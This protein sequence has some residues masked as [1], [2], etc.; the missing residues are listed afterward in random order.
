MTDKNLTIE[1]KNKL[2]QQVRVRFAPS[3]TGFLH[4]GGLR[5]ALYNYLFAKRNNGKFILRIEDT[6]QKRYVPGAIE[7]LVSILHKFGLDYDEGPDKNGEYGPYVQSKRIKIYRKYAQELI[8]KNAAYYCFC[9]EERLKKLREQRKAAKL[10]QIMYDGHCRNLSKEEIEQNLAN[11]LPYVIRLKVP[12][13]ES[14]V[15]YDKVRGKI[16][17]QGN[18]IDDQILI[19]SDGYPTYHLA[20]V[21]DDHLMK[22]THIIRG[23][24]W[25]SSTPKHIIIYNA[26]EWEIPKF[27]HLPLL[28]NPDGGKL[29]KRQGDVAVEDYLSKGYLPEALL[30]FIALLGWHAANDREIYSLK[31]MEKVFSLKRINK[32]GAVFDI[33]KLNW[34]SGLYIRQLDVKDFAERAKPFFVKAGIDISN[35]EKYLKVIANAQ[36]RVSNLSETIDHSK[37]FYGKLNFS[38]DDKIILAEENS[39]KIYSYWIKHL[40]KQDN[41][42][43]EDIKL[44]ERKTIEYLG[45]NGKE[46]YFPLRLALFGKCDG[47]DIPTII[48]ILGR[49]KTIKRLKFTRTLKASQYSKNFSSHSSDFIR[50]IIEED[51]RTNK[52]GGRVHTRFPPE[53]NGYL[54]IGHSKSICLNFGIA[55]EYKGGLCNLRF[56]DTNPTKEDVEYVE[57]IKADIRWLGF[58]WDDRLFYASDYFE[59]LYQYAVQLIKIG[60]AYVCNLSEQEIRKYRG[61]VKEPGKDSPYRNRSVEENLDLFERMRAGE[62]E[63]GA[64]VLR[65]KIDMASPNMKMRDPL[66]YRIRHAEHH[67]TG[68]KWCIYPMYDFTHCLSDSIERITHSLCTLEFENNRELYDWFLDQLNVYHPQQI[69]F[70]RLNISYTVMSKRKLLELVKA[71]Y[72]NGWD[73]PRMPT[74][75]GLRRRGYTPESIRDF[76]NRIGIAKADNIVDIALLEHCLREDLNKRAP[77]VMAVLRPLR[78]VIVNYPEDKLEYI[79]AVN[80]PEDSSMGTRKLP[81]SRVLYI[82]QDDFREEPPKKFYRLAPGR[83]VRLRYA[84]F[85]KCV[86]VVK[87]G[88]TGE[89]IELR[90]TYDPATRGGDSPDG[91]KVKSTLHWVS[92]DYAIKAEVRLYD[93]LFLKAN[94][95]DVEQ[96]KD[97]KSNLNPNSLEI[98]TCCRVEPGLKDAKPGTKFQ[99]ERIGYFCVD[100]DSSN[101][102]LVFNRTVT[103]RDTWAKIEKKQKS[104]FS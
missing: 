8:T 13:N 99:F 39:Q 102:M 17:I 48:D 30:N 82:E 51:L 28:L 88:R 75:C 14:I 91:R 32:A 103:L 87:D 81:F 56:D 41:W 54:H 26:L 76:C 94:P 47:P 100:T 6:D 52:Y 57:S 11:G 21:V 65:A 20:N 71:G 58:D 23:E 44:L 83:E 77:R 92:A 10:S 37:M 85:I 40:A 72:V 98:L 4:V 35:E 62:F 64:C 24:E 59:Q 36:A 22:I 33:K 78:L 27:V 25:L 73:D 67:R 3:P 104:A 34:M 60:K 1:K 101:E 61:T 84:Y 53:P 12:K 49:D 80:N 5:T 42:S 69:E 74:I 89:V 63:D 79:D 68:N 7:N 31:Q 93:H 29:S 50:D 45:L 2:E 95:D 9:S 18:L 97:F 15:F 90:C 55:E 38:D 86:G 70:A 66:I 43:A 46:L 16:E 96:G 19:K